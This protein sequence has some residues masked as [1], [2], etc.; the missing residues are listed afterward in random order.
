MA[1]LNVTFINAAADA[2]LDATVPDNQTI[3][4]I[5]EDLI[6]EGF[7]GAPER[8]TF[9]QYTIKGG[10]LIAEGQTLPEAGTRDRD[11]VLIEVAQIGGANPVAHVDEVTYLHFRSLAIDYQS[12]QQLAG[13]VITWE[14]LT[15]ADPPFRH[16]DKY[17]VT[18]NLR[19]PTVRGESSRHV[20]EIDT[21]SLSYPGKEPYAKLQTDVV[22]HPHIYSDGRIC[23]RG[24]P[25]EE[26]LAALC[27]RIARYLQYDPALID[28]DSVASK[29][30]WQWYVQNR[31]R[32]PLDRTPLPAL[33]RPRGGLRVNNRRGG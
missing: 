15:E 17:R 16:P 19:A 5:Q 25:Q 32:L 23:L 27:V 18:F 7:L 20:V 26:T 10:N 1:E 31:H 14:P 4:Q 28:K 29:E 21:S 12:I 8:G 33:D 13:P 2:E 3:E 22:P 6:A 30:F 24:H 11:R 9:Y